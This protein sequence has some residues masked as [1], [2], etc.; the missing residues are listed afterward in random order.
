MKD[1]K[2]ISSD[3]CIMSGQKYVVYTD[4]PLF[5]KGFNYSQIRG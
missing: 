2:E 1:N 5:F 3:A 4:Q